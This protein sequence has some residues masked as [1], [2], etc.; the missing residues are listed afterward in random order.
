MLCREELKSVIR[1]DKKSGQ[2]TWFLGPRRGRVAG[3]KNSDGYRVIRIGRSLYYA[4]RL[5]WLYVTGGWP[6]VKIDH[7][8][9]NHDDNWIDNLREANSGQNAMNSKVNSNNKSG[10]KGVSWVK[11][12]GRWVS[13]IYFGKRLFHLGYF[14]TSKEAGEVYK[15]KATELFGCFAE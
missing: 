5:A 10:F 9:R 7:K 13:R 14:S 3:C 4:H 15:I 8:N 2:F 12:R 1:Y 6:V 11:S